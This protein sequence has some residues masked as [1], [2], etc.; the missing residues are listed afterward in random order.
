MTIF[1]RYLVRKNVQFLSLIKH[2][3]MKTWGSG[4]VAPRIL[5]LRTN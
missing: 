5:H 3:T 1:P 2:D 4:G